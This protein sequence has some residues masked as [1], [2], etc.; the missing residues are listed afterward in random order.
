[1]SG[2]HQKPLY[3]FVG[4]TFF[5]RSNSR[6]GRAIR[7]AEKDP[8]EEETWTNHTGV[9]VQEVVLSGGLRRIRVRRRPGR[10]TQG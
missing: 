3:A 2:K 5:T 6:L 8:G 7:W 1:M 9:V 4:D 10:T